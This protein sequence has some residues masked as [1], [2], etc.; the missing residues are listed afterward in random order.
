MSL[1][2]YSGLVAPTDHDARELF[3][4]M[5]SRPGS[6]ITKDGSFAGDGGN[7]MLAKYNQDW[8]VGTIVFV[9]TWRRFGTTHKNLT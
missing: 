9:G 4:R 6:I 7:D 5:N 2:C 1:R 3:H 8:T